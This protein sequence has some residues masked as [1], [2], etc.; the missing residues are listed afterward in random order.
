[1]HLTSTRCSPHSQ[2]MAASTDTVNLALQF[3]TKCITFN[4][5]VDN[6]SNSE[7]KKD[8]FFKEKPC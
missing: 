3:L 5:H 2:L 1:M 6:G 7:Q 4:M 8:K